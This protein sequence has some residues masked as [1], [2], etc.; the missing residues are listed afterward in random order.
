VNLVI[1][2]AALGEIPARA[3]V[4]SQCF[5]A[6]KSRG[7]LSISDMQLDPRYQSRATVKRLA[8]AAGFQLKSIGGRLWLFAANFRKP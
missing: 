2:L 7:Q 4:L 5:P 6:L 8:E 1:L 3:A